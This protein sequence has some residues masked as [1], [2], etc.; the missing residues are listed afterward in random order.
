MVLVPTE[1][2]KILILIADDEVNLLLLIKDNLEEYGYQ[3][4][5]AV[6]GEEALDMAVS[7]RPDLIILDIEMPKLDGW[8]VCQKIRQN[9]EF[10]N[11]PILILSAYVQARD[12]KRGIGLGANQYLTKPFKIREL[13]GILKELLHQP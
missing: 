5:T 3:V 1:R 11:M 13:L 8:Q 10:K 7:E 9:A 6:D 2:N 12:I 4:L